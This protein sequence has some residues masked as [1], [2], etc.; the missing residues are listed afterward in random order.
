MSLECGECERDLRGGHAEWC[1]RARKQAHSSSPA[2]CSAPAIRLLCGEKQRHDKT[3]EVRTCD[4]ESGHDGWCHDS[5]RIESWPSPKKE[6]NTEQ[7]GGTSDS[8]TG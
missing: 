3:G 5:N 6:P 4:R 7:S 8:A 2:P 1:S